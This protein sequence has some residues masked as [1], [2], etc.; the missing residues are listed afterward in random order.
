MSNK[1]MKWGAC[2]IVLLFILFTFLKVPVVQ[3]N[4]DQEIYYVKE[5][6]FQIEWIHSVEKEEWGE[7]Y[8][9]KGRS[10]V[11]T[12]TYFKTFGAGMPSDGEV[13]DSK[14]GYVQMKIDRPMKEIN[15]V[16]SNNVQTTI[17]TENGK[18][19]LYELTDDQD[20]VH[21]SVQSIHLWDYMG[22]KSL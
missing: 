8:E 3:L 4:F 9:R 11:L 22:G 13:V 5:D 7:V 20:N 17:E 6:T 2:F 15:L 10:I 12:E 18:T 16:V 14:E 19:H 21:I 1:W